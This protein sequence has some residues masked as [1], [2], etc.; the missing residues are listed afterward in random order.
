MP[1]LKTVSFSVSLTVQAAQYEPVKLEA[2][3]EW[4]LEDYK[5]SAELKHEMETVFKMARPTLMR[6]LE[7]ISTQSYMGKL[8]GLNLE[9]KQAWKESIASKSE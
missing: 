8:Q 4:E 1:K 5:D 2:T 3:C 9:V 7:Q 6:Q